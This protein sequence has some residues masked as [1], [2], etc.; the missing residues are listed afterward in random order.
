LPKRIA[1]TQPEREKHTP[2][3]RSQAQRL[4]TSAAVSRRRWRLPTLCPHASCE[5]WVWEVST[6]QAIPKS[7]CNYAYFVAG[8]K[9]CSNRNTGSI[10]GA[11]M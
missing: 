7:P 11:P 3:A 6:S 9:S 2:Q 1:I 8:W 10:P 5:L 4:S